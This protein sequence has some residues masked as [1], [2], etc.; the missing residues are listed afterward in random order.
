MTAI[1]FALALLA[2]GDIP[3]SSV[4]PPLLP[5]ETTT[6]VVGGTYVGPLIF[7]RDLEDAREIAKATVE[8][9]DEA[10]DEVLAKKVGA[11]TLGEA[12]RFTVSSIVAEY[13][14]RAWM[15]VIAVRDRRGVLAYGL[16]WL[17]VLPEP[18]KR[19]GQT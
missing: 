4:P 6:L 13:S 2:A 3:P 18:P 19:G 11:C 7:C 15:T 9:G 10:A 12:V 17:R 5:G 16:T 1:L 8:R 14:G